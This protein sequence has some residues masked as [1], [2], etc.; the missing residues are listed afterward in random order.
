MLIAE[1]IWEA[2][3]DGVRVE[4]R[5]AAPQDAEAVRAFFEGLSEDTRWLRYHSPIPIVRSWMV[6]AVVRTDHTKRAA[7]LAIHDG[8]IV[9]VAEWGRETPDENIA[10][11][12][13]VVDDSFRRKGV[14]AELMRHLAADAREHGIEA[15]EASVLQ[16]NRPTIGLI[17]HV[18]PQRTTT[19]DGPVLQVRIPLSA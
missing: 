3:L 14:A 4:I 17:Q 16:V 8:R 13:V 6:D 12:A 9:G 10:H 2:D 11:T 19:F 1:G 5:P 18:A 7:L 15:F